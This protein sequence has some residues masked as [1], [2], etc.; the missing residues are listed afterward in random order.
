MRGVD[1]GPALLVAAGQVEENAGLVDDDLDRQANGAIGEAVIVDKAFRRVRSLR[2]PGDFRPSSL[3]SVGEQFADGGGHGVEP[4]PL[5]QR[6]QPAC[7]GM[8]GGDL[9]AKVAGCFVFGTDL[10]EDQPGDVRR[11]FAAV[12]QLDRRNDDALLKDLTKGADTGRG[13][14]ADV[15]VMGQVGH[16]AEEPIVVIDRGDQGDVVE[17]GAGR[18]GKV[19]E[20]GV[21][22]AEIVG[23][24][25][26]HGPRHLLGHGAE[27]DRLRERLSD[28]LQTIVEDGTGE[29]G[30]SLDVGGVG[31]AP[32]RHR[33][34]LGGFEE[35]VANNLELDRIDA[36]CHG[37]RLLRSRAFCNRLVLVPTITHIVKDL[38]RVAIVVRNDSHSCVGARWHLRQINSLG[39]RIRLKDF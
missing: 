23:T 33:H 31:A 37:D 3:F 29:I 13:A 4:L 36:R 28:R 12:H 26:L 25:F 1:R 6:G 11:Q 22:G 7:P 15:D 18:I 30:P 19:G 34:L 35:G 20:D 39:E 5:Q 8:V 16:V 14:A 24:I 21:A 17:V 38:S 2:Q 32:Q 27:M 10:G 9:G